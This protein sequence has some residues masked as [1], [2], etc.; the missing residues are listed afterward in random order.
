MQ[1][2]Q[3]PLS[4]SVAFSKDLTLVEAYSS[5]ST[6]A[7]LGNVKGPASSTGRVLTST[8][9][10]HDAMRDDQDQLATRQYALDPSPGSKCRRID[11][12]VTRD[13]PHGRMAMALESG[14]LVDSRWMRKSYWAGVLIA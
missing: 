14:P 13:P 3:R 5:A 1:P 9:A 6:T 11:T 2:E 12:D 7:Y 4:Y 10:S 8:Q